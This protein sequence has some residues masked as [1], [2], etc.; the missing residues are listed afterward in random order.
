MHKRIQ[1]EQVAT[2]R[3]RCND[4]IVCEITPAEEKRRLGSKEV[5]RIRFESFVFP[6]I[7]SQEP[8]SAGSDRRAGL[9]GT[10]YRGLDTSRTR[11]PEIVVRHEIDAS[12]RLEAAQPIVLFRACKAATAAP[13]TLTVQD[14]QEASTSV[15]K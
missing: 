15:A 9:E 7:A 12:A 1:N 14:P 4:R 11:E 5:G 13:L 6:A 8:R 10:I 3:Q 2:L